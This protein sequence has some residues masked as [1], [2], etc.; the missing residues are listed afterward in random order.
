MKIFNKDKESSGPSYHHPMEERLAALLKATGM[1]ATYDEEYHVF[2]LDIVGKNCQFRSLVYY[3]P[4]SDSL[5]IRSYFPMEVRDASKLK[6]AEL[7]MRI[8]HDL[9]FGSLILNFEK[10]YCY[11]ETPHLLQQS[12]LEEEVFSRLFM[13]NLQTTDDVFVHVLNVNLGNDEPV[14][15]ALKYLE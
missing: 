15:A 1:K 7:L 14:T 5:L 11:F 12:I 3:I 4:N 2:E 10:G 8:N 6:V 13:S 9:N